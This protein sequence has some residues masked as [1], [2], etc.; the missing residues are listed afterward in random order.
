MKMEAEMG[1]MRPQA[2]DH[3]EPQEVRLGAHPPPE[4]SEGAWSCQHL[5]FRHLA[6]RLWENFC[7]F[8]V[9][10]CGCPRKQ[11]DKDNGV[12]TGEWGSC[13]LSHQER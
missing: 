8:V 10:G 2:K 7:W 13:H 9:I 12:R 5:D 3:L 6:S 1:G 4:P 11:G